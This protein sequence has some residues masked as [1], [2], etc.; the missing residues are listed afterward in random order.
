MTAVSRAFGVFLTSFFAGEVM[1]SR[2][3]V[4]NSSR[5]R[6]APFALRISLVCVYSTFHF[7]VA[8]PAALPQ[9]GQ[10]VAGSGK[11][12]GSC[13]GLDIS[14]STARGIIDWKSFSIGGGRTVYINNG[15]G[16]TLNR[17]TGRDLSLIEGQLK[18]T[19]SVYLINPQGIVVGPHGTITTGGRFVA[20]TL[21][22][23]N[24]DFL[25]AGN[26][27]FA[28]TSGASVVNLGK[29][30]STGGDVFLI[31]R[32]L[33]ANG[34]TLQATKGSAEL[35]VGANVLLQDSS[36]GQQVFVDAG[37]K[38]TVV[39]TGAIRAAQISLQAADGNIYAL[40]GRSGALRAT[41]TA[42][43]A[44][45]VWLVADSGAVHA[46]GTII[47]KNADGTGGT[48]STRAKTLDFSG[49]TVQASQWTIDSPNLTIDS[50]DARAVSRSLSDGTSVTVATT[51]TTA[52]DGTVTNV[53]DITLGSSID[54]GGSASL[55]LNAAG[56][57]TI[58]PYVTLANRGTG[59]LTLRADAAGIDNGSSVTN[60]GTI[61]WS[62]S[63][64]LVSALYDMNGTYTPGTLKSNAQWRAP[65]YSGYQTQI[66]GYELVNSFSD[67][68]NIGANLA[69]NYALGED[70]ELN[71]NEQDG[72]I[73][74]TFT[75]QLDGM[76]HSIDSVYMRFDY[77]TPDT[78]LFYEI[79]SAGVV[80]NFNLTNFG[81]DTAGYG[82]ITGVLAGI[83]DGLITHVSI[84]PNGTAIAS[85]Q[86]SGGFGGIV[87]I[88]NGTI[89]DSST[90][91]FVG[92]SGYVGGIAAINNGLIV[93]SATNGVLTDTSGY[94]DSAYIGGIASINYGTISQSSSGESMSSGF[95]DPHSGG[96]LN[97]NGVAGIAHD[98]YGTI[99]D[100]TS[101]S[102]IAVNNYGTITP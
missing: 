59:D 36:S 2:V 96:F 10:F 3:I 32:N 31:S 4:C 49:A 33:V 101:P 56:S 9:G 62:R 78:G 46:N 69:G 22:T 74:G 85:D 35:D 67:L 82:G 71:G 55:A 97:G 90:Y 93:Q 86:V 83:N 21:D 81:F 15:S 57:V 50:G 34:G 16:A 66:T 48:V 99:S 88:N 65:E 64:G 70:L 13:G 94:G 91:T 58:Q 20:S 14:Q 18:A 5:F 60:H 45:E 77:G 42:T 41:G 30:S 38:G 47:A 100:S 52:A 23:S 37:S 1:M 7:A 28:G 61:D 92:A 19:G 24:S 87:G 76:G 27:T 63:T 17:V 84:A 51:G 75:G 26:A 8:A 40:A 68:Q 29:I 44:G 79:G 6:F 53:G 54:W 12:S 72:T 73:G 11:I 98:N 25:S 95:E 80:R 43:R 102:G 39:N 89:A